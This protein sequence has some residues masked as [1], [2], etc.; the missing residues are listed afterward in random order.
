MK[1]FLSSEKYVVFLKCQKKTAEEAREITSKSE[2]D[3]HETQFYEI[4][5]V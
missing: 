1:K 2:K 5:Y 3:R 4:S